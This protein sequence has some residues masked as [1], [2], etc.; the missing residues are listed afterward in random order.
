MYN[1]SVFTEIKIL[2]VNK[3]IDEDLFDIKKFN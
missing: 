3:S 2:E 1:N